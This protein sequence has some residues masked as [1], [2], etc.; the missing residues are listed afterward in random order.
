MTVSFWEQALGRDSAGRGQAFG[1]KGRVCDAHSR[2]QVER[3]TILV[4]MVLQRKGTLICSI[5][6]FLGCKYSHHSQQQDT[7]VTSLSVKLGREVCSGAGVSLLE[8]NSRTP[9]SKICFLDEVGRLPFILG[10]SLLLFLLPAFQI[11]NE[12]CLSPGTSPAF[13]GPPLYDGT[14]I[15]HMR[16]RSGNCSFV[17]V[18]CHCLPVW[19]VALGGRNFVQVS[20]TWNHRCLT[21]LLAQSWCL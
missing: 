11:A 10:T 20:S 13:L 9:L 1:L 3:R 17:S 8:P 4:K 21:Q 18:S 5:F 12:S 19:S 2:K 14:W 7:S 15:F 6:C 16:T